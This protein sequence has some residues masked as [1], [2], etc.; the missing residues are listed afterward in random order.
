M[1]TSESGQLKLQMHLTISVSN[2]QG[3]YR[4]S[5]PDIQGKNGSLDGSWLTSS[6]V[7]LI[8]VLLELASGARSICMLRKQSFDLGDQSQPLPGSGT[9]G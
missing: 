7:M 9:G 4:D 6:V 3:S 5:K 1:F 8:N 2:S